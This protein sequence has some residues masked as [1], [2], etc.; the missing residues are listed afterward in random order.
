VDAIRKLLKTTLSSGMVETSCELAIGRA[1]ETADALIRAGKPAIIPAAKFQKAFKAFVRKHDLSG[2]L[3]SLA[4]SPGEAEVKKTLAESPTFVRQLDLVNMP[5]EAKLQAV[6]DYLQA[7]VNKTR[8]ADGGHILPDSLDEFDKDLVRHHGFITLELEHITEPKRQGRA[9]YGKCAQAAVPLEGREV[10]RHFV[11]GCFNDLADRR[12]VGWH[13]N[14]K[15]LL[16][17]E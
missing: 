4:P 8:W 9:L 6:S 13:P 17:D 7:S 5:A 16:P 14:F 12:A 10:P 15:K 3:L 2:L 11:P 1:K